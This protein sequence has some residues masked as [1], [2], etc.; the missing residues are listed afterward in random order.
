MVVKW[1]GGLSSEFPLR[2]GTGQGR[3][4]STTNYTVFNN[5]LL[6]R[7]EQAGLG[8]HIGDIPVGTQTCAND[9][10]LLA[11]SNS[12]HPQAMTSCV[13]HYA[14]E[15]R[16]TIGMNKTQMVPYD[17]NKTQSTKAS[18]TFKG[19]LIPNT[20][21]AIQLGVLQSNSSKVN[22]QMVCGNVE[23]ARKTAYALF[24]SGF[25]GTNGM[26]PAAAKIIWD[27]HILS[28]LIH[29]LEICKITER[30]LAP[31]EVFC[32]DICKQLLGIPRNSA[33]P[34]VYF[35]FGILPV[36]A[37]VHRRVLSLFHTIAAS[38][39]S[40]IH[41][42]AM[43]QLTQDVFWQLVHLCTRDPPDVQSTIGT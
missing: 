2:Q 7:I 4:F 20:D 22:T 32:R 27:L 11:D 35:L 24:G 31:A 36:R 1:Q 8:I 14:N 30:E 25:H 12:T 3:S 18:V 42:I 39:T 5:D 41:Q 23:T 21:T 13:E 19:E 10:T 26:N 38:P 16:Y 9:I 34:A 15:N 37:E 33:N 28:R 29:G 43:R 40:R 17:T 6:L